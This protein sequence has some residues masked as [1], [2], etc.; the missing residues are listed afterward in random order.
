MNEAT[1]VEANGKRKGFSGIQVATKVLVT[2]AVT[3]AGRFSGH[4]R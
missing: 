2:V 4:A 3:V 1:E